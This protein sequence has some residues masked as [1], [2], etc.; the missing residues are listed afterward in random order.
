MRLENKVAIVTGA[1]QGIGKAIAAR[2]V[3]EGAR[4]LLSDIDGARAESAARAISNDAAVCSAAACDVTRS[5]EI[6]DMVALAVERYG[7]LDIAVANAGIG[8][9]SD[10]LALE[11][12][13]FDRVMRVNVNGVMLTVQAAARQM[14]AQGGGGSIVTI[15]S[16]AGKRVIPT[17]IPY[18]TSKAAVNL[19]TAGMALALIDKG[20]RVNAVGPGSTN[21]ELMREM[22]FSSPEARRTVLSRTPIGR[23][24][25]PDEIASVAL[26][27]A[28]S[29]SSYVT[30]QVIFAEGGRLPLMYTVP[31]GGD[32]AQ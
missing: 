4:V 9:E 17:Q 16:I 21:T 1:G 2:F 13:D 10:F 19:M 27:L 3:R 5:G 18:C 23:P 30:G 32:A 22:V 26:F 25:E 29:E 12:A 11:E 24:A 7:R 15:G 8:H 6:G 28:S 20:I 14:A 31:V